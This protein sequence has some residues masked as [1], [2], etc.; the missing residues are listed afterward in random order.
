VRLYTSSCSRCAADYNQDG[1]VDGADVDAFFADW[2][3]GYPCS[4][5]NLDGGIDGAD[6]DYFFSVW[7]NGGC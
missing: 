2:E 5:V 4:D 1:G 6:V 3:Q 7:E